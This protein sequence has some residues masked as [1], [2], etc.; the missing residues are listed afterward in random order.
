MALGQL[1]ITSRGELKDKVEIAIDRLKMFEPEEGYY[2][3]FS[4][5]KDSQCIYH[6]CE[7]AGVKFDAHFRVTSVDPPEL[8]YFIRE[9]Y[10]DVS[11]EIPHDKNGKRVSMWSL[12][13]DRKYPPTRMVR[14]CCQELKES[15]GFGRVTVTGVRWAESTNRKLN[16]GFVDVSTKNKKIIQNALDNIGGA[17]LTPKGYLVLNDDN[18]EARRMVEQCFRTNKTMVNPIVDW[19]DDDVWEFLNDVAKVQHCSLYDEGFHRIGCIGCPMAR[20][21]GRERD[22]TRWPKYKEMYLKTFQ[23]MIDKEPERYKQWKTAQDVFD[24][25]ING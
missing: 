16:Q 6:L 2:V 10:P 12:I 13:P 22:F 25:W 5:G 23:K 19:E 4:G 14:Y 7:M 1:Q 11:M 15:G 8:I 21:A 9:H 17:A 20:K 3:A 24:W 18:D